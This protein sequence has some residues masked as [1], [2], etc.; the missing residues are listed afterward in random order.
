MPEKSW[1]KTPTNRLVTS[2]TGS[3]AEMAEMNEKSR[4]WAGETH[5][6]LEDSV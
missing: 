6:K 5:V 2:K 4:K 3:K 1:P